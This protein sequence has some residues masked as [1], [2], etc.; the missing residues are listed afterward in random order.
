MIKLTNRARLN[1]EP[2]HQFCSK[3]AW[4]QLFLAQQVTNDARVLRT[5]EKKPTYRKIGEAHKAID[6]H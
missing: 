3:G 6:F 1:G 2:R 4:H 5:S